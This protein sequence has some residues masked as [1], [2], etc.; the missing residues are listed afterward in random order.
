M[1]RLRAI[2][3]QRGGEALEQRLQRILLGGAQYV[4][5]PAQAL[6]TPVQER[7]G[8]GLTPA[9]EMQRD[10]TAVAAR[11]TLEQSVRCQAVDRPD[12]RGLRDPKHPPQ[13]LHGLAGPRLQVHEHRRRAASAIEV[14]FH[15]GP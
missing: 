12:R 7:I 6:G 14:S 4:E 3:G 8:R 13:S 1:Q 2:V 10:R 11:A 15:P 5:Q 9:G